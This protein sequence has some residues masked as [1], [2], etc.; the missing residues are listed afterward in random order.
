M[1]WRVGM[2]VTIE[3]VGLRLHRYQLALPR[4]LSFSCPNPYLPLTISPQ[5]RRTLLAYSVSVLDYRVFGRILEIDKET[6]PR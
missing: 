1:V 3:M 2:H 6:S 5:R 4:R